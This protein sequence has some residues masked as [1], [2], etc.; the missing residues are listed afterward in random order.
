MNSKPLQA[1]EAT[2][3]EECAGE[4]KKKKTHQEEDNPVK[5]AE[6]QLLSSCSPF[7]INMDLSGL[8]IPFIVI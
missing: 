6:I 4:R 2:Q 1:R 8:Q 7:A 3:N 5:S